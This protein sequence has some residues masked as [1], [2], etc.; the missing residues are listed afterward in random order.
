[1]TNKTRQTI[2]DSYVKKQAAKKKASHKP[3]PSSTAGKT[4][5]YHG[6]KSTVI[7]LGHKPSKSASA[8]AVAKLRKTRTA[9]APKAKS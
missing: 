6:G 2:R 5:S 9:T 3:S 8:G 4:K 1:M 7:D